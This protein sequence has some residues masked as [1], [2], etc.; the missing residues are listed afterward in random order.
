MLLKL[1]QVEPIHLH[2]ILEMEVDGKS[3]EVEYNRTVTLLL[4]IIP[5]VLWRKLEVDLDVQTLPT[6]QF[7]YSLFL[8][9]TLSSIIITDAI[10]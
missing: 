7:M 10:Q 6:Y 9:P 5:S 8:L 1:Q 3:L 4:E 2:G